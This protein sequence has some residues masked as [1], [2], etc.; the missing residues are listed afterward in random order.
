MMNIK[1]I[2]NFDK[3]NLSKVTRLEIK[4]HLNKSGFLPEADKNSKSFFFGIGERD[5]LPVDRWQVKK[6]RQLIRAVKDYEIEDLAI[7][8]RELE[9][10]LEFKNEDDFYR[11]GLN[12]VI[13]NY[14]FIHYLSEVPANKKRIKSIFLVGEVSSKLKKYFESGV[15]DGLV[16]NEVRDLCNLRG[17]D[18]TPRYLVNATKKMIKSTKVKLQVFDDK[19]IEHLKMGGLVAVGRGSVE[20]SR[21]LVLEYWGA[22]KEEKP[23]VLVGKGVTFDTGG[24]DLKPTGFMGDMNYDMSGGANV[25]GAIVAI[26]RKEI[27]RNVI[28]LIPAVENSISGSSYRPGDI[29]KMMN[30]KTVEVKNTDAEGRLVLAD[31][32][33]YASRYKPKY[34][35]DVATLTGASL[36]ALGQRMSAIFANDNDLA[37]K[38][39][40]AGD[41]TGDYLWR[42][43]LWP[44]DVALVEGD[45]SDLVNLHKEGS[46]YGGTIIGGAF[47]SHFVPSGVRWAH[48]DMA[49]RMT[50]TKE[51]NLATGSTGE[52]MRALVRFIESI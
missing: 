52:P 13:A 5:K 43:P 4:P 37:S 2:K 14:D 1:V 6:I 26:A 27:K 32:L 40:Q 24:L 3:V 21:F 16:A 38:L 41:L 47:L 42:L 20:P 33:C 30:G 49:P 25:I 51:D 34:L 22:N 46:R 28:A 11:L 18:M 9:S 7:D 36:V 17:G 31:A 44:E 45:H 12:I 48:I 39:I 35:I 15:T 29:I 23:V 50:S 10:F 8:L 19:K